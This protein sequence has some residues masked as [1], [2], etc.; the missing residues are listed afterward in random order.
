MPNAT[1]KNR[2]TSWE[3]LSSSLKAQIA[4]L[5]HL[6]D[7]QAAFELLLEEGLALEARQGA[8]TAAL[9]LTNQRRAELLQKG[10]ALYE[11]LGAALRHKFGPENK[12]L[13]EFGFRPRSTTPRRRTK[14][15]PEGKPAPAVAN[16]AVETPVQS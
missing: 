2:L 6:Q 15:A 13:H 7:D 10:V 14:K 12:K 16:A 8:E 4:D 5:P 1:L 11:R 9:R 3:V